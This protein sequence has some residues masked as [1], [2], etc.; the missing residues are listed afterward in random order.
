M[1]APADECG[2]T[3]GCGA[4]PLAGLCGDPAP[5]APAQLTLFDLDAPDVDPDEPRPEG[6]GCCGGGCTGPTD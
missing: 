3:G 2:V 5:A 1:S 6:A 4:C